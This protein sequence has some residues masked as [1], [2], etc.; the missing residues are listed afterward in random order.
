[1]MIIDGK[2]KMEKENRNDH[3]TSSQKILFVMCNEDH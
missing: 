1:M 3:D 2:V